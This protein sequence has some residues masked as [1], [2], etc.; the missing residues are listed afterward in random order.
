MT[1][2]CRGEDEYVLK[3]AKYYREDKL[4]LA[5]IKSRGEGEPEVTVIEYYTEYQGVLVKRAASKTR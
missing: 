5:S 1:K 4:V 3:F 2:K